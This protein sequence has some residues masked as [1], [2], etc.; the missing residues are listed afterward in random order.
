ML[1]QWQ[2]KAG[3]SEM[4]GAMAQVAGIRTICDC[5]ETLIK[6]YQRML[7]L[8]CGRYYGPDEPTQIKATRPRPENHQEKFKSR[9]PKEKLSQYGKKGGTTPKHRWTEIESEYVRVN[10]DG[11]G[12]SVQIMAGYL[13]MSFQQVKSHIQFLG[14]A[15]H[16]GYARWDPKDDDIVRELVGKVSPN[17][18]ARRLRPRRTAR[19]VVVRIKRLGLSRRNRDGWYTK[20]ETAQIFGV[21]H[22]RIQCFIDAGFLRA[23]YHFDRKPSKLGMSMWHIEEDAIASFL[24]RHPE[25]L[26]GRNVDL[27]QVVQILTRNNNA[28]LSSM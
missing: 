12:Q 18:I 22:H 24:K 26:N 16:T 4:K 3:V 2:I 6:D 28:Q 11:T 15:N 20:T 13:Q 19:A 23:S 8:N 7:C 9:I 25:E 5:G 21:G 10:Y 14:I 1:P 17:G 27:I